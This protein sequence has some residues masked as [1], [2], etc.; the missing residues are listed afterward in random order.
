[1][2]PILACAALLLLLGLQAMMRFDDTPRLIGGLAPRRPRPVVA[3]TVPIYPDIL[4]V[5]IF[6]PDRRPGDNDAGGSAATS[7]LDGYAA[8]GAVVGGSVATAVLSAPG[9]AARSLKP[10]DVLEGW[11]LILVE[12]TKVTFDR[13]GVRHSLTVGAPAESVSRAASGEADAQ[14]S[15]SQ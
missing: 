13:D 11:R 2:T 3:P 1:M 8:L 9:G 15:E 7:A 5:P 14:Q 12:R 10:G 4:R 6:T